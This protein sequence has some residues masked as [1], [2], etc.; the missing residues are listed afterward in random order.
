MLSGD[1][2]LVQVD[3]SDLIAMPKPGLDNGSATCS[4]IGFQCLIKVLDSCRIF[5]IFKIFKRL[6]FFI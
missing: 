3:I 5:K 2:I 4:G 6:S 1:L